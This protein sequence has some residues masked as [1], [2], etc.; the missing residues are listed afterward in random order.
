MLAIL[1]DPNVFGMAQ[2]FGIDMDNY[3]D[4][5]KASPTAPGVDAIHF[6]GD[7]ERASARERQANGIPLDAGTVA[8]LLD[9][10][11]KAN[12]PPAE[13]DALADHE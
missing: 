10:A 7:P 2:A 9:A 6:P 12:V 8:Q 5:V 4:W 11:M 1:I 13:M 3:A